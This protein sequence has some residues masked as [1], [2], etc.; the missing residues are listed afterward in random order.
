MAAVTVW[1][2]FWRPRKGNLSLL[3]L[4]PLLFVSSEDLVLFLFLVLSF[5]PAFSLSSSTLIKRIFSSS[6]FSAIGVVPSAYLRLLIFLLAIL[7][8]P[9]WRHLEILWHC[10]KGHSHLSPVSTLCSTSISPWECVKSPQSFQT[11]ANLGIEWWPPSS[12]QFIF[13]TTEPGLY[14]SS[15]AIRNKKFSTRL[16]ILLLINS[17]QMG[18]W[19]RSNVIQILK[20]FLGVPATAR[21]NQFQSV[22][23]RDGCPGPMVSQGAVPSYKRTCWFG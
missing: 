14:L 18:E 5:K 8:P 13:H 12:A 23:M 1:G 10:L 9:C 15:L 17:N 19:D 16:S 3:L 4:F 2:D 11:L 6:S 20:S 22:R 21:N 7:I